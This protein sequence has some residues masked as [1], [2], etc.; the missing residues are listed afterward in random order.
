LDE[1]DEVE[2]YKYLES[3]VQ[4]DGGFVVD[5][6]YNIKCNEEA[7][8]FYVNSNEAERQVIQEYGE[9]NYVIWFEGLGG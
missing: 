2:S 7:L 8:G 4:S 9:T 5:V 6:K 1:T 3:F